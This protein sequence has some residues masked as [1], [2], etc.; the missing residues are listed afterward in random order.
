M[1]LMGGSSVLDLE[2]RNLDKFSEVVFPASVITGDLVKS[3]CDCLE[4][5]KSSFP[6][7]C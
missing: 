3:V 5:W 2:C 6:V 4:L 7:T 1:T